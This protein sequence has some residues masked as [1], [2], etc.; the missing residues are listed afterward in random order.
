MLKDAGVSTEGYDPAAWRKTLADI[1]M[2]R[3]T[4]VSL[5]RALE[6]YLAA[7]GN[8]AFVSANPQLI[9]EVQAACG[10]VLEQNNATGGGSP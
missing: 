7:Y 6:S 1:P 3:D 5:D 8:S 10:K 2:S 9:M 4:A